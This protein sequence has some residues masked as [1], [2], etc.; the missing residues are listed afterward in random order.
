MTSP[1]AT[2]KRKTLLGISGSGR[3]RVDVED[4]QQTIIGD[5]SLPHLR[6]SFCSFFIRHLPLYND[7]EEDITELINDGDPDKV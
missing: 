5:C 4:M 6:P 7:S 1:Q 2:R 3:I